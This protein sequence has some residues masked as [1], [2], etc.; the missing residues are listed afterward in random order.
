M[1]F[2]QTAIENIDKVYTK[3]HMADRTYKTGLGLATLESLGGA[4]VFKCGWEVCK[5]EEISQMIYELTMMKEAIE[6]ATGVIA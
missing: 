3:K 6:E 4:S 5:V 1:K 2:N